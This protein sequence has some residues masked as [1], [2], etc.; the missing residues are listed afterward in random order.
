MRVKLVN[1]GLPKSGTTTLATALRKGGWSVADHK[2]RRSDSTEQGV[3]GTFIG[4]QLYRGYFETGNP[5]EYLP[6]YDALTEISALR[7]PFSFWPQCDFAMIKAMRAADPGLRFVASWRPAVDISDSMRRWNNLGQDRLPDG[8]IPGLPHGF[9]ARDRDRVRWIDGHYAMLDDIF[10]DDTRYLRL[11]MGAGDAR[12][13]LSEHAGIDLPW[14]GRVNV[15]DAEPDS[16][17]A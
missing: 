9:G 7:G 6:F 14:W 15:N 3:A 11:D 16:G 12:Q 8:S 17:A 1:L 2:V 4:R 10:G 5:F 13:R